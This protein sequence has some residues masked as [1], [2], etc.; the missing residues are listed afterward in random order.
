MSDNQVKNDYVNNSVTKNKDDFFSKTFDTNAFSKILDMD[1]SLYGNKKE[2]IEKIEDKDT[3]DKNTD[4][5]G[6]SSADGDENSVIKEKEDTIDA[7]KTESFVDNANPK[8]LKK[9][10]TVADNNKSKNFVDA[11]FETK[12][13]KNKES[14]FYFVNKVKEVIAS[15]NNLMKPFENAL[16]NNLPI[17]KVITIPFKFL[18]GIVFKL[19]V[20]IVYCA[21]FARVIINNFVVKFFFVALI[22]LFIAQVFSTRFINTEKGKNYFSSFVKKHT[23]YEMVIK[24]NL[25]VYAIPSF[26]VEI[27]NVEFFKNKVMRN[28]DLAINNVKINKM[29]LKLD[30]W[31]LLTKFKIRVKEVDLMRPYIGLIFS[32]KKSLDTQFNFIDSMAKINSIPL[33]I[34]ENFKNDEYLGFNFV[35]SIGFDKNRKSNGIFGN[36]NDSLY[37]MKKEYSK[38]EYKVENEKVDTIENTKKE[39]QLENINNSD[40]YRFLRQIT[41]DLNN[42]Y[43]NQI[44]IR[45]GEVSFANKEKQIL[46][47]TNVNVEMNSLKD[48]NNDFIASVGFEMLKNNFYF[49]VLSKNKNLKIN[50]GSDSLSEKMNDILVVGSFDE[51]NDFVGSLE[52]NDVTL[53]N[54]LKT[55]FVNLDVKQINEAKLRV[56][57]LRVNSS[58]IY[59]DK[60]SLKID[61]KDYRGAF[62]WGYGTTNNMYLKLDLIDYNLG[63]VFDYTVSG[64]E[65]YIGKIVNIVMD[66]YYQG[67]KN[68]APNFFELDVSVNNLISLDSGGNVNNLGD[69]SLSLFFDSKNSLYVDKFNLQLSDAN[70]SGYGKLILDSKSGYFNLNIKGQ[71]ISVAKMFGLSDRAT[72]MFVSFNDGYG[73]LEAQSILNIENNK[74]MFH[75]IN[76]KFA[77]K[78]FQN[79]MLV[80]N[81]RVDVDE[82]ELVIKIDSLDYSYFKKFYDKNLQKQS[83]N[84]ELS[85][86][87]LKDDL[88]LKIN[89]SAEDF[90]YKNLILKD[91]VVDVVMSKNNISL[92]NF[93]VKSLS[94]GSIRGNFLI[95]RLNTNFVIGNLSF[96]KFFINLKNANGFLFENNKL[97]GNIFIDGQFKVNVD[98]I[99]KI[100]NGLNGTLSVG[101]FE[102]YKNN[103]ISITNGFYITVEKM[104]NNDLIVQDLFGKLNVVNGKIDFYPVVV[105]FMDGDGKKRGSF[106]GNYN[107][108]MDKMELKGYL[109]NLQNVKVMDFEI[110]GNLS[111][112]V[113]DIKKTQ[114][115]TKYLNNKITKEIATIS[116]SK[117]AAL[118]K[119]KGE[120]STI[121]NNPLK[122][123]KI[124]KDAT[125]KK[126]EKELKK[127]VIDSENEKKKYI[128]EMKKKNENVEIKESNDL[129]EIY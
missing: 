73:F 51:S 79:A 117:K 13:Y 95:D 64:Y 107:F 75:N 47:L 127:N 126:F 56:D 74:L 48:E 7:Q 3:D 119:L 94:S 106:E 124:G 101:T 82:A 60:Y 6:Y 27:S 4:D 71:A 44:N 49:N 43:L 61:N 104:K 116:K 92:N 30:M 37:L 53:L 18:F 38:L 35:Y 121:N 81:N 31:T 91:F 14:R 65:N 125:S 20:G 86:L 45:N 22:V 90:N 120:N 36:V 29:I 128:E 129:P 88:I 26:I 23:G 100:A 19:I 32:S 115:P 67:L 15:V 57:N 102:R 70:L 39:K 9:G 66:K 52:I 54:L 96:D 114:K 72:D 110:I 69:L 78:K 109:S 55:I 8:D 63:N 84:V 97:Q 16:I 77:N 40:V 11:D 99:E 98:S 80:I 10:E 93:E 85:I 68:L 42:E 46:Y 12:G 28:N 76:G 24:G 5:N 33:G 59:M 1:I 87:P 34:V 103:K 89:L 111:N 50:G 113:F 21:S 105:L 108:Y 122:N 17:S 112:P 62:S 41:L 123:N 25:K 2:S 118:P 58:Y 83:E